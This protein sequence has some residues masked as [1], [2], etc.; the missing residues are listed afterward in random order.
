MRKHK[1]TVIRTVFIYLFVL[2]NS[3]LIAVANINGSDSDISSC[4]LPFLSLS[5]H[6]CSDSES[7][8]SSETIY[9]DCISFLINEENTNR[10]PL[11]LPLPDELTIEI[12][13]YLNII[14]L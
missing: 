3:K 12:L 5:T 9:E 2:F 10:L 7:Y 8:E 4:D 11:F 14:E 13:E 1:K 6:T